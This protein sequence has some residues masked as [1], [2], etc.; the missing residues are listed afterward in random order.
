MVAAHIGNLDIVKLL[1]ERGAQKDLPDKVTRGERGGAT[2]GRGRLYV[3]GK[4]SD[5][6]WR[7]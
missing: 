3:G 5:W 4:G 7:R 6:G 2:M 1:L